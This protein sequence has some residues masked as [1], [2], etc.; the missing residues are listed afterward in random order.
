MIISLTRTGSL[1]YAFEICRYFRPLQANYLFSKSIVE[2][3]PFNA[4]Y[5]DTFSGFG[6][7]YLW[8]TILLFFRAPGILKKYKRATTKKLVVY[9]PVFHAWNIIWAFWA[10]KMDIEIYNTIH[11]FETHKGEKNR[12]VEWLQKIVIAK[13]TINIFLSNFVLKQAKAFIGVGSFKSFVL[14]HPILIP[15]VKHNLQYKGPLSVL[16]L[17]RAVDYKGI[18]MLIDACK[19]LVL[20]K[21]TIAGVNANR[22]RSNDQHLHFIDKY[23]DK[24]EMVDLLRS[25]HILVLP[26]TE[27][28]QSGILSLGIG[29]GI[30]MVVCN[31]GGLN[32]QANENS[33]VWVDPEVNA[34]KTGLEILVNNA[35]EYYTIKRNLNDFRL[36][37]QLE[38]EERFNTLLDLE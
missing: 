4:D 21:L 25:H 18:P 15:P 12:V 1:D 22:Y 3:P 34:L 17:G 9:F 37:F 33:V 31:V 36:N 26:Y 23:L 2:K 28:T 20:S 16:F 30:P 5:I 19:N 14:P 10:K 27:A 11:D 38:W 35:E 24:D 13:S 7:I 29:A 6:L 32:E 8:R